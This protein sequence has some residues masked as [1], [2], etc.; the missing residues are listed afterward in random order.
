MSEKMAKLATIDGPWQVSVREYPVPHPA[1]DCLVIKVDAAAICGSDG[2]FIKSDAPHGPGVDGHEF[3]GTIVEMGARAN[4]TIH[5]Y[6]GEMKVGDR[7]AVYP[8]ISC[9]HCDVCM[10]YGNGICCCDNDFIYGGVLNHDSSN[11][12]NHDPEQWPHFKGGFGEYVYIFPNTFVW[13]VP[14]GMPSKIAAIL[15][16][17]AVA[18]RAVEQAMTSIG[19]LDEG[20]S[21]TSSCLVI[22]AGPIGIMTGMILKAMGVEK[23]IMSDFMDEKLE[24]A[25]NISGADVVLNM[26]GLS[27]EEQIQKVMDVTD[28]LGA[29]V[30]ISA[31]NAPAAAIGGLQMVRKLGHYVEIGMAGGLGNRAPMD[32]QFHDIVFSR[33]VHITSVV[34]NTPSCFDRAFR[35]LKR[36]KEFPFDKL[37]THEFHSFDEFLPTLKKMSDPN[38]LKGV[39]VFND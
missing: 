26:A 21:T 20:I 31:A 29:N 8:H 12:K 13:K 6:G 32:V 23:L 14:E 25:K 36:Y 16:P 30:V 7:I 1:E 39:L 22:G 24:N 9:Q 3:V 35:F 34:A 18:M 33:N 5:C 38:Y 4:E 37:V 2:H 10:T 19:G 28:G 17:M 27:M 11:I 15:D